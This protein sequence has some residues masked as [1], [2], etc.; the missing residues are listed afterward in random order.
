MDEVMRMHQQ[1]RQFTSASIIE[2]ENNIG[3]WCMSWNHGDWL[4]FAQ[5]AASTAAIIGAYGVVFVQA[6]LGK[7]AQ[8]E[9]MLSVIKAAHSRAKQFEAALDDDEIRLK[10]YAIYHP[11]LI[12]SLVDLMNKLPVS[13]LG[14]DETINAF[15]IFSGQF[16]FL[17]QS[18]DEYL[19]GPYTA[20]M[21]ADL[22]KL[23]EQGYRDQSKVNVE[24][25]LNVLKRNVQVHLDSI[26]I[27][28]K[29]LMKSFP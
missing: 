19:A 23:E 25:K 5:A 9:R 22:Q 15:I 28:F 13:E 20:E 24:A 17:K 8:R 29:T 12:D 26:D 11:S 1:T 3:S 16:T 2:A 18:L 14:S 10:M 4:S 27:E 7:R 6:H 21:M